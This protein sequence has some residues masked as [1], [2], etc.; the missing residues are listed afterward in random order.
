MRSFYAN[1]QLIEK[2]EKKERSDEDLDRYMA[3]AGVQA[4]LLTI[5]IAAQ[6]VATN[7][8]K[9]LKRLKDSGFISTTSIPTTSKIEEVFPCPV[10]GECNITR[11]DCLDYSGSENHIHLCQKCNCEQFEVTRKQTCPVKAVAYA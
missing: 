7:D 6:K 5:E 4:K 9:T 10:Q 11:L 8:N 3:M 2:Y 1:N